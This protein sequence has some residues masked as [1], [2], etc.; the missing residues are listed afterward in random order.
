MD[1]RTIMN[2]DGGAASKA[3]QA[4]QSSGAPDSSLQHPSQQQQ[5]SQYAEY[6]NR[7]SQP[8][9]HA[10]H[11]QH[12]SPG[13]SASFG[14][15]QSPYQQFTPAPP[16]LNT[17]VQS[18][19]SQSPQ[20]VSTPYGSGAR[21]PYGTSG[22]NSHPQAPAGPLAS[23]YTPQQPMSAGP[24]H[25]EQQSY[26]A[27]QRSNSLQSVMTNPLGAG[28]TFRPRDSPPSASHPPPSHQFSPSTH[29][30]IPG[31][32]LGPPPTISSRQSPSSARPRSSGRDS[33]RNNLSSPY[34]V[35]ESQGRN[36]KQTQSPSTSRQISPSS[37]HSES[38][39]HFPPT[40]KQEPS[41]ISSPK[42]TSRQNSTATAS[43]TAGTAPRRSSEDQKWNESPTAAFPS[44]PGSDRRASPIATTQTQITS[45]PSASR[46]SSHPLK[47][48][49]DPGAT[50]RSEI[51][52]PKPKRR[53]Y[54]EPPIYAQRSVRTKGR[55]PVIPNPQAPI[56]K[57]ARGSGQD[58][59]ASRRQS[60]ASTAGSTTTARTARTPGPA[61]PPPSTNGPPP[62]PAVAAAP[63]AQQ[64]GSLGPWEPSITGLIPFEEITK[65]LCDFLF[66][67]VVM[68]TDVGTGAAGSAAVGQGALIEI[69]AKLGHVM[70]MDRRERLVLPILTEGVI[71]RESRLRTSFESNMTVEQHR[72]MNN[73]LNEQVKASMANESSRIPIS[74][75]HKKERDTF[76]E[77][78][79][80]EL[81]PV[82][83]Q[84][85]NPRH[86]PKVRVTTDAKTGEIIAKIVK[87][88]VADI[89][90]YSP[91]TNVDWRVSVN[92]EMEY[93]GDVTHLPMVDASK[94]GR[95]ERNKDRMSYRHLAYQIDLTQVA[96][97][98]AP[99]KNDFDHELEVEVSADEIRR[100]GLLAVAGDPS[101]QYEELVK[102][103]VDNIRVLA[104]A[105]PP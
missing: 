3:P 23:P 105:V 85:L 30:S 95:G 93:D 63:R 51:Q 38:A 28:E 71:N 25:S 35:H 29:R 12:A 34:T 100:Q 81:P 33:P 92:L 76:Y 101:N 16:P 86:K 56:P 44:G 58:P 4:S 91:R 6:S 67:H 10:Q 14:P 24:Q 18:H 60:L 22:Y 69:E 82:I 64:Q 42:V 11:A 1:L 73:F 37:R 84:N 5:Q 57:H 19:P 27:Q 102:G 43:D 39:P 88:R 59:W 53:R 94:G 61:V 79:P 72:A 74:Y 98:E 26:F 7:S 13:R 46:S 52:Q 75:A 99:T 80:Q 36:A 15:A 62:P 2:T 78:S 31:T 50:D 104:R 20:Q 48:E 70:D 55:C 97:V 40:V 17:A 54:N 47:M 90:V 21:D 83:R 8:L 103:F 66:Q 9:Q 96:T 32:P 68:R 89:D 49:V 45:S 87:C 65:Q 77:I 41:E